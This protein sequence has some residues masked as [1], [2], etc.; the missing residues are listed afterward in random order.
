MGVDVRE[1]EKIGASDTLLDWVQNGVL[2]KLFREISVP[3]H[4]VMS[5]ETYKIIQST[6]AQCM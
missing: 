6:C 3:Y 2:H 4:N 5:L 1:R